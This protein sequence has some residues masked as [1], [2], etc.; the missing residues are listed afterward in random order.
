MG[1]LSARVVVAAQDNDPEAVTRA[2]A[3][4]VKAIEA[5]VGGDAGIDAGQAVS[6]V[7]AIDAEVERGSSLPAALDAI[8]AGGVE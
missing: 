3:S 4:A 6:L 7:E 8:W 2:W 5:G 1:V